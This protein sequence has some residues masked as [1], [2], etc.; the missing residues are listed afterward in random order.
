MGD[1]SA[2]CLLCEGLQCICPTVWSHLEE[3]LAEEICSFLCLEKNWSSLETETD[4]LQATQKDVDAK[5]QA[6]LVQQKVPS[7]KVSLWQERAANLPQQSPTREDYENLGRCLCRCTPNLLHRYR[8]GR[9][10]SK[11]LQEVVRL[12]EEGNGLTSVANDP[13]QPFIVERPRRPT[14][15]LASVLKRL[16]DYFDNEDN[17]IIGI[18]GLGGV[19]KTTLLNE[20]NN[21]LGTKS[22]DYHVVI[23]IEVSNSETLNVVDIQ[24]MIADR[25]G[26]PWNDNESEILRAKV[27]LRALKE[28]KF[29]LLLDDVREEFSLEAVGIP[30]PSRENHCKLII[31]SRSKDVCIAMGAHQCLIKMQ[32]LEEAEARKLFL[33]NLTSTAKSVVEEPAVKEHAMAIVRS[34]GG[35]PLAL[36]VVG[37]AVAGLK[38]P[39]EWR[40]AA[41]AMKAFP[42]RIPGV[43]DLVFAKLKYSYDKLDHTLQQCFLYCTLFPDYGF[44]KKDQLVDYWIAEGLIEPAALS[45][46]GRPTHRDLSDEGYFIIR[47]LISKS[48]LQ[49]SDTEKVKMHDIIRKLGRRLLDP[50][51]FL[52]QAGQGLEEAPEVDWK[53]FTRISLMSNDLIKL[54]VSPNCGN[55]LTLLIQH[56]PNLEKL[57]TQFFRSMS[58]LRV[59]DL[60]YTSIARLPEID[61]LANLEHLNLCYTRITALPK[62]LW[63]LKQLRHLNLSKTS[64]LK[65]IPNGTISKLDKLRVLNLYKSNYGMWE[66]EDLNLDNLRELDILGITIYSEAVLRK[67]KGTD[68]LAKST[69]LLS[70]KYCEG[71]ESIL[72]SGLKH[73]VHLEELSVDS[74]NELKELTADDNEQ[75]P[76]CLK[77]LTLAILPNLEKVLVSSAG[78]HLQNLCKLTIHSCPKLEGVTWVLHLE[79]LERLIISNCHGMESIVE[80]RINGKQTTRPTLMTGDDGIEGKKKEGYD[81]LNA[82]SESDKIEQVKE[83]QTGGPM[84]C[85]DPFSRLKTIILNDLPKLESICPA[86]DFPCLESIRVE[87]CPNLKE[88]PLLH[89]CKAKKLKQICGSRVWWNNLVWE[90]NSKAIFCAHFTPI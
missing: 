63:V 53:G 10:V 22:N 57:S 8:L 36:N 44:I 6:I 14:F 17:S 39:R 13:Q 26:L 85:K 64:A 31:A 42:E 69:H 65:E 15:G 74:C 70:L 86:R 58:S 7:A 82:M 48:L 62:R 90:E 59:L 77:V 35:L 51:K 79:S 27:L 4:N 80:E 89:S 40:H 55:L 84:R 9:K 30:T 50:G 28:K 19:G 3:P 33:S 49:S 46:G 66:V 68:P 47:S 56:N 41:R 18:W 72:L 23:N 1:P 43:D 52:V 12:D 32:C 71:M 81:A 11:K 37:R 25:W 34:C 75:E 67:L 88:L 20:F 73:M 21:A 16:R 87:A 29:V 76:S 54:P 60:S 24:Q 45:D 61:A 38:H 78:L 2:I 83:E 5:V